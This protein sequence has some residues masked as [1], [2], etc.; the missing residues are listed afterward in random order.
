MTLKEMEMLLKGHLVCKWVRISNLEYRIY[1][2]YA[3]KV[4]TPL[5]EVESVVLHNRWTENDGYDRSYI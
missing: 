4:K 3:A 2:N 5:L 1:V